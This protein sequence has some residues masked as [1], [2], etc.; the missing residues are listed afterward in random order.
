[1]MKYID[2]DI[3][4]SYRTEAETD[5]WFAKLAIISWSQSRFN[6][7]GRKETLVKLLPDANLQTAIYASERVEY[8]VIIN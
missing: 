6:G 5:L 3:D 4:K 2:V 8:I 7:V 1:M